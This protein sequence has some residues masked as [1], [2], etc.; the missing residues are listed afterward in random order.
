MIA[1]LV[2]DITNPF[3]SVLTRGLADAVLGGD[4]GTDV[5]N[6]DGRLDRE[7]TFVEDVMDRGVDGMVIASVS[8]AAGQ[9]SAPSATAR[10]WSASAT[11]STTPTSTGWSLT[12]ATAPA[13]P[14]CTCC[15]GCPAVAMIKGPPHTGV[16]R[17]DGYARAL[18]ETGKEY[19]ERYTVRG[20]WTRPGGRSAMHQL[21][22][23]DPPPDAVFCANDLM[24]IGAMDAARELGVSI[25]G[26]VA[27]AGFRHHRRRRAGEPVA[28]H[29]SGTLSYE[30][31]RAAGESSR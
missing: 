24:A 11:A 23:L 22:R 1:V 12:T 21:M 10:R 31:G 9:A 13:P 8:A 14:P 29:G 7:R 28:D 2:P 18:G 5:C 15:A 19:D 25:P 26:D 27:L 4:Y 20:D 6:T 3:Y 30:T 17:V 16:A